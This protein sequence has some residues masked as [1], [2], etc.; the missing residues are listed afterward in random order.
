[1]KNMKNEKII[2]LVVVI[3]LF[4]VVAVSIYVL[5]NR[6]T[7]K[8]ANMGLDNMQQDTESELATEA[9]EEHE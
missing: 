7:E 5:S 9:G 4:V 6:N 2:T 8:E 3:L 1:M